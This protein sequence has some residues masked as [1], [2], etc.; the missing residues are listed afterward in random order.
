MPAMP[1]PAV[2]DVPTVEDRV[3]AVCAR[4]DGP[5]N[6]AARLAEDALRRLAWRKRRGGKGCPTCAET[7]PVSAFGPDVRKPDGLDPRCRACEAA[8]RRASRSG[9]PLL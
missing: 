8:R 4:Y 3:A 7:K 2:A 5:D 1:S 9:G 6:E